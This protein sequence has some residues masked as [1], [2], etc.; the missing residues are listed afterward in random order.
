MDDSIDTNF[1]KIEKIEDLIVAI[2]DHIKNKFNVKEST[3][4]IKLD[5]TCKKLLYFCKKNYSY[6][7]S[8]NEVKSRGL[9]Y[10]KS[11]TLP[12]A[13]KLQKELLELVLKQNQLTFTELFTKWKD[14]FFGTCWD[15][16]NI[17][18]IT[19]MQRVTKHP[20]KYIV[21]PAPA[22]VAEWMIQNGHLFYNGLMVPM[23]V[24]GYVDGKIQGV[25]PDSNLWYDDNID[26]H[27]IWNHQILPKLSRITEVVNPHFDWKQF[28]TEIV[29]KRKKK[30]DNYLSK[31]LDTKN[32]DTLIKKIEGDIDLSS[33][34]K[35]WLIK[36]SRKNLGRSLW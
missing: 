35:S 4:N 33:E 26:L 21:K 18:E 36:K 13:A 24:V 31:M 14:D 25:H 20:S 11:S 30:T 12:Y 23:I 5:K 17:K 19:L 9:D 15:V 22:Q 1:Y 10:L 6:V 32:L 28:D 27:Y 8:S 3:V 2:N 16:N 7:D 34:Q 29:E